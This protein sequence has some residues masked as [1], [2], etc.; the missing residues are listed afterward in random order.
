MQL[1]NIFKNKDKRS[2][3]IVV[4]SKTPNNATRAIF[5]AVTRRP[6]YDVVMVVMGGKKHIMVARLKVK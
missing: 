1:K 4:V 3:Y 2:Y 5:L 6:R